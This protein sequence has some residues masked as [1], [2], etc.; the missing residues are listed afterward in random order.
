MITYQKDFKQFKAGD[1]LSHEKANK[2][3]DQWIKEKKTGPQ[4]QYLTE[5][6]F[7]SIGMREPVQL[8]IL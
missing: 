8:I 2:R 3:F 5:Q 1:V 4:E 7:S 6:I